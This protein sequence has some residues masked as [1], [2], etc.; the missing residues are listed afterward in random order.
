MMKRFTKFKGNKYFH[1]SFN[2]WSILKRGNVHLNQMI[3]N[4]TKM[5]LPKNQ[6][7]DGI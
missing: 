6:I 1:S 5:A 2:S 4:D 3:T 7:T